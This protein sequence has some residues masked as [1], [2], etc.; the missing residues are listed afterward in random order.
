MARAARQLQPISEVW[1]WQ[2]MGRCRDRSGTQF[3]HPDDDLGRIS[4]RLREAAAKRVCAGCPVRAQ[5][6]THA[7]R[8]GE[9]YGVWG[10]FSET[11]RLML[12]ALGWQDTIDVK[13]RVADVERLDR[14]VA[15]ARA[16]TERERAERERV[17]LAGR[18]RVPAAAGSTA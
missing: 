15:R 17:R 14:R 16:K 13:R 8:V 5:C 11:E 2:L 18:D 12:Q 10:G 6:A 9:E 3:F 1:E 4:R 7:L